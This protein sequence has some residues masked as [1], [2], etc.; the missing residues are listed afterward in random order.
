M[1][2]YNQPSKTITNN[3]HKDKHNLTKK[4]KQRDGLCLLKNFV[5]KLQYVEINILSVNLS[6]KTVKVSE[7]EVVQENMLK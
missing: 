3:S 1:N 7:F 4:K 5:N 6:V 2:F